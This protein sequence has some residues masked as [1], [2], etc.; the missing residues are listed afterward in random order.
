MASPSG[1]D[2]VKTIRA[3]YK[4][5]QKVEH[6]PIVL[7]DKMF[8]TTLPSLLFDE[9]PDV[10]RYVVKILLLLTE[11]ADDAEVLLKSEELL[12]A[13][14][15]ACEKITNP[16]VNYNVMLISSRLRA[17][18]NSI[19]AREEAAVLE[20]LVNAVKEMDKGGTLHRKFVGRKSKQIVFEFDAEEFNEVLKR[21]VERSLLKK[22]GVISVYLTDMSTHP[23]AVLRTSPTIEA[24]E[25][26]Q[27]IFSCGCEYVSQI[28]K[29]EG[30]E[31]KFEMYA[32]DF[33]HKVKEVDYPE[34][35]DDELMKVDPTNCV[36]TNEMAAHANANGGNGWFN[37][38]S[39]FVKTSFW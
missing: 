21:E 13:L 15:T 19:K 22:K 16:S 36:I 12:T 38:I 1:A 4:L 35:L 39:S 3:Y 18:Q 25:I 26:A 9:S 17:I 37:S 28:V 2:K 31:E 30:V 32:S 34:Y 23:R 33:E 7:K 20:P 11:Q 6:R 14:S 5:C 8:F 27:L 24:K 10:V 29:V